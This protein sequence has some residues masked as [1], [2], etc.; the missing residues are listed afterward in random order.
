MGRPRGF[1]EMNFTFGAPPGREDEVIPLPCLRT[2][3]RIVSCWELSAAELAEVRR[4]GRVWLSY[5]TP[6]APTPVFVT[7]HK[8]EVV[9]QG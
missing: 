4:T 2:P 8:H 9:A 3:G 6:G 5:W 7:G 1:P